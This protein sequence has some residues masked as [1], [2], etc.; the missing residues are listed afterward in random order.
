[1]Q[2]LLNNLNNDNTLNH[3]IVTKKQKIST[4]NAQ[5]ENY[6]SFQASNIFQSHHWVDESTLLDTN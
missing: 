1:M 6:A 5:N 4:Q 2:D 3:S